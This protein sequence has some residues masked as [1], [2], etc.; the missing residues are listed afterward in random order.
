M[1]SSIEQYLAVL[2]AKRRASATLKVVHQDLTHFVIWWEH[3]RRRTFDPALLRHEDLRDWR[4][5]RQR[6][7]GVAPA[8][9]NRGLASLRG[10]CQ[11]ATLSHLLTENPAI[12]LEDV[13]TNPLVPRSLPVEAVDALLRNARAERHPLLRARNEALLALLIY[14][15]LRVQEAC[16]LQLRDL[17]LGGGK[18]TVRSGKAGKAR[19]V[20]LHADAQRLLRRYL[21]LVRCPEGIPAIGS[22]QK[23]ELLLVG[24]VMTT[25]GQPTR[26]GVTQ[27]VAQR[28][29]Q[30]LGQS[31]VQQLRAEAQR[32]RDITRSEFLQ[33]LA[34]WLETV[35]PH[36]LRHSLARRMLERGA[37]LPEVQRVLGHSRLS[38]TGIYLTPSEED[39]RL[40][41]GRA[42][43]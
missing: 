25:K 38:T 3:L 28:V 10:Y 19:R 7:D 4:L 42:G 23:R 14:A 22:D 24:M 43:V 36:M 5:A 41:I 1:H 2:H 20:P 13:P 35:T 33:E 15:G 34:R 40:A 27:R 32:E 8:T 30:Q 21:E 26:V 31:A 39:V 9:I 11:W 16:A 12:D 37:Q 6:D 18:V 29:V 17:D